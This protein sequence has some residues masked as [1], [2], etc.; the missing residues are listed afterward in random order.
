MFVIFSGLPFH[1]C[2][3][4][5]SLVLR[6]QSKVTG[7]RNT[8]L[9]NCGS[10]NYFSLTGAKN[11]INARH[12]FTFMKQHQA[13]ETWCRERQPTTTQDLV[14]WIGLGFGGFFSFLSFARKQTHADHPGLTY[15]PSKHSL[16]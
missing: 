14:T 4:D 6:D 9:I 12:P 5:I 2:I 15:H 3:C 10:P 1:S 11:N 8:N 7:G 13:L 16:E